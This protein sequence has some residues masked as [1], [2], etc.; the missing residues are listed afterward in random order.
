MTIRFYLPR[1]LERG[2]TFDLK[3]YEVE[4]DPLIG[5]LID[6]PQMTRQPNTLFLLLH[7]PNAL[8][9][10]WRAAAIEHGTDM[11]RGSIQIS[12]PSEQFVFQQV[13]P[14]QAVHGWRQML[15]VLA[16]GEYNRANRCGPRQE[17]V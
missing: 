11:A 3:P 16:F 13:H 4:N 7:Q 12:T 10:A 8:F 15:V 6:D 5:L 14:T 9:P 1:V 2:E 17:P